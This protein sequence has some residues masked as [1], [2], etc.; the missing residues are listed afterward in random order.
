MIKKCFI[1]TETTGLE[2]TKHRVHQIAAIITDD[3]GNELDSI[4]LCFRPANGPIEFSAL[5]KCR[6]TEDMLKGRGMSSEEGMK[7]FIEFLEKHVNRFDKQDKLHFVAYNS[8]FDEKFVR[9][10]F[11]SHGN[12]F[13][14]SYFWHPSVCVQKVAAWMLQDH[15]AKID[16]FKLYRVCQYLSIEFDESVAHDAM[17]DV[18]KTLDLY[19]TLSG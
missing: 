6:L 12:E 7:R 16:R 11:E 3:K 1:D 19:R 5:E 17:Y 9:A 15:R 18:R 13:F 8:E 14:S 10:W 4:N 2:P